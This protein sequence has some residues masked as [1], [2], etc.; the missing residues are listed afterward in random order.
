VFWLPHAPFRAFRVFVA[1][2]AVGLALGWVQQ[3]RGAHFLTHTLAT[4]WV[5]SAVLL[6][7]L[8][9]MPRLRRWMG[10]TLRRRV[11]P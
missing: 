8:V 3:M 10:S 4:L 5:S 9:V 6:A 2:L 7:V 1:G 11:A